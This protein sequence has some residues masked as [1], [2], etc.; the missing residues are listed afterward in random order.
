MTP[1][2]LTPSRW[3][4]GS[5]PERMLSLFAA[6]FA[7]AGATL[8]ADFSAK[9]AALD[10]AIPEGFRPLWRRC[11]AEEWLWEVSVANATIP[12]PEDSVLLQERL[13]GP[14]LPPLSVFFGRRAAV[15]V[16]PLATSGPPPLFAFGALNDRETCHPPNSGIFPG[17][18]LFRCSQAIG[19]FA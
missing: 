7:S 5:G 16:I 15:A 18:Q 10:A 4:L 12:L 8:P 1:L 11:A 14:D 9:V 2:I 3:K 17:S 13:F 6:E 19:F